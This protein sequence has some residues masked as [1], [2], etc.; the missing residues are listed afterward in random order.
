[1]VALADVLIGVLWTDLTL[2][3]QDRVFHLYTS[4][5]LTRP[6]DALYDCRHGSLRF[7]AWLTQ[8]WPNSP[9]AK[10]DQSLL[11][12]WLAAE[13]NRLCRHLRPPDADPWSVGPSNF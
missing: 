8:D 7:L 3:E 1:M 10:V 6:G 11:T 2:A 9:G 13:R 12:R 4:D 5:H